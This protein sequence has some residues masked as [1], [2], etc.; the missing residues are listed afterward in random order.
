L[1]AAAVSGVR[2]WTGPRETCWRTVEPRVGDR[3]AGRKCLSG[4]VRGQTLAVA[5][6][7]VYAEEPS[8]RYSAASRTASSST[9]STRTSWSV[10]SERAR[11]KIV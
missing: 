9:E 6:A 2:P 5:N 1:S 8:P 3:R 11:S 7:D 10:S 4:R